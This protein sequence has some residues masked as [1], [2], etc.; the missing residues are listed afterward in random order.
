MPVAERVQDSHGLILACAALANLPR[1]GL[2]K[3]GFAFI[4][5]EQE[6]IVLKQS[7]RFETGIPVAGKSS[8]STP[9]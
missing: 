7:C 5:A 6:F 4:A 3:G 8:R 2:G 1:D 9:N